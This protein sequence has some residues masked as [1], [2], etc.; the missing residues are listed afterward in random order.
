MDIAALAVMIT[1]L[2]LC[3]LFILVARHHRKKEE[4]KHYCGLTLRQAHKYL[5]GGGLPKGYDP[6]KLLSK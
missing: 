1:S 3:I 4:R 2:S 5:S 6:K